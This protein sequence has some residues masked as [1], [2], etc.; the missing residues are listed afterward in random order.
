[1]RDEYFAVSVLRPVFVIGGTKQDPDVDVDID[2]IVRDEFPID[3]YTGR[4]V[5]GFAP[6]VHRF[7]LVIALVRVLERSPAAEQD[8]AFAYAFVAW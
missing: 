2:Q 7:V 6:I 5:H 3:D 8:T 1:M 4:D